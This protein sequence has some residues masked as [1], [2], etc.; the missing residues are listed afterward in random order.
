MSSNIELKT[1][2][3]QLLKQAKEQDLLPIQTHSKN[4]E[5]ESTIAKEALEYFER[6]LPSDQIISYSWMT[7]QKYFKKNVN[8]KD[9]LIIERARNLYKSNEEFC[10]E[11]RQHPTVENIKKYGFADCGEQ[12]DAVTPYFMG[13]NCQVFRAVV[14]F[15]CPEGAQKKDGL[16]PKLDHAFLIYTTD[17]EINTPEK[18]AAN[19]DNGKIFVF[20]LWQRKAMPL[21]EFLNDFRALTDTKDFS[22]R[23]KNQNTDTV[24]YTNYDINSTGKFISKPKISPI[25]FSGAKS[26]KR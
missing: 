17:S 8:A 9:T 16:P 21:S 25:I 5:D 2:I 13:K 3:Q 22:I 15:D 14:R 1:I 10:K 12:A 26:N 19:D 4:A 24:E 18:I 11:V 20:D 23:L 7:F 6:E